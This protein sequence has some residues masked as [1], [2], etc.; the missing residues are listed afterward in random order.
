M[1]GKSATVERTQY[2]QVNPFEVHAKGNSELAPDSMNV[3]S[4]Q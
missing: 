4:F 2:E 1:R 3:I